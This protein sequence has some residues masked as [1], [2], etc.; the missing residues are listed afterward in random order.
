M[1][2]SNYNKDNENNIDLRE[3][4]VRQWIYLPVWLRQLVSWLWTYLQMYQVIYINYV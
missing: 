3:N 4:L 1:F 2:L